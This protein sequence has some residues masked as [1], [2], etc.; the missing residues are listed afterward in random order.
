M[1]PVV[2]N[3]TQNNRCY[4]QKLCTVQW[5]NYKRNQEKITKKV[6]LKPSKDKV[7]EGILGSGES[8]HKLIEMNQHE[9]S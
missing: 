1:I 5:E 8:V 4:N 9:E 3:A 6:V 7:E 2:R